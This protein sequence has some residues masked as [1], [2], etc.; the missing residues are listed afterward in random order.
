MLPTP[1][2]VLESVQRLWASQAFL[3]AEVLLLNGLSEY[4]DDADLWHGL[5][6]NRLMNE[7]YSQALEALVQGVERSQ[8]MPQRAKC[9]YALGLTWSALGSH[10]SAAKSYVS[11]V[12][13]APDMI[14]AYIN[15]GNLHYQVN[16]FDQAITYYQAALEKDSNHFG[17][18][19]N[20]GNAFLGQQ[21]L[22]EALAAYSQAASINNA[23]IDHDGINNANHQDFQ[24]SYQLLQELA[25][26]PIK[27]ARYFGDQLSS[28]RHDKLAIPYYQ[29]AIA[30]DPSSMET[31]HA[32]LSCCILTENY[33]LGLEV[34][35]ALYADF[36]NAPIV[37]LGY[38]QFLSRYGDTGA[39]L[40]VLQHSMQRFPDDMRWHLDQTRLLPVVYECEQDIHDYRR[41][42][43]QGINDLADQYEELLPPQ[44]AQIL[45]GLSE[46]TNFLFAYQGGDVLEAQKA[47]SRLVNQALRATGQDFWRQLPLKPS[48]NGKIK[49]GF[50]SGV[51]GKNQL[52]QFFLGW[53]KNINREIF[54]IYLYHLDTAFTEFTQEFLENSDYF[55]RQAQIPWHETA[56]KILADE[57]HILILP[58]IGFNPD[59]TLMS[60]LRLAPIQ[61]TTWAHPITSGSETIDYFISGDLME[62]EDAEDHYTETLIRLPGIGI[63]Y[64]KPLR[65][66]LTR[67][68][69]HFGLSD[70]R[71][72]YLC[73]QSLFKYL[74]QDDWVWPELANRFPKVQFAFI[75]HPSP[76]VTKQ[77][78]SRLARAFSA[79]GLDSQVF[80]V[81]TARLD[82][83]EYMQLNLLSDVFLDSHHWSGGI[84]TMKAVTCGLPIVTYPSKFMRGR[85]SYGILKMM[86]IEGT[87]A[88]NWNEYIDI[89]VRLG[90]DTAWRQE[91]SQRIEHEQANLFNDQSCVEGLEEF[92][93]SAVFEKMMEN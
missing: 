57:L 48:S 34:G 15:L 7:Q 42:F 6:L 1:T 93:Q 39:C 56:E 32:L 14:D 68:R 30:L 66:D 53:L 37:C 71:T 54:E 92:F 47:Y 90:Q 36:P 62:P 89:A 84:T 43:T 75:S 16:Q 58:E 61:C 24:D 17:I 11:A 60:T 82:E 19:W 80:C 27:A 63:S 85:H 31:R 22:D 28:K 40:E 46:S 76:Y 50:L 5:G 78:Q 10:V 25:A 55:H 38:F 79:Y 64:P 13:C 83:D 81:F 8:N 41:S 67:Q 9:F 21:K 72:V 26:D 18:Y 70:D 44:Q 74:P 51:M 35:Q 69:S 88:H 23:S 20:L 52:G 4:A 29:E 73:C 86:D 59:I 33:Q 87:I 65:P 45:A 12:N 49:I 3:E 91:V 77:F 2:A